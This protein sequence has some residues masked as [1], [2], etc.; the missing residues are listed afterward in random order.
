MAIAAPLAKLL[1][2]DAF[3]WVHESQT[4]FEQLKGAVM[5]APVLAL[6][7]FTLPFAVETDTSSHAMGAILH[8]QGHP[9]A[10][11][12]KPFC[13]RLQMA[14]TYVR[15]LHAIVAAVRKWRQ[16]LLGHK[17]TIYT[18]HCSLCELMS[19][20]VQ[21]PSNSFIWLSYLALI[22]IFSIRQ[23]PQMSLLTLSH[24]CNLQ[25]RHTT[26]FFPCLTQTS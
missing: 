12:S 14:S 11:F 23:E 26:F 5:A 17:F 21:T 2:K 7:N 20:V 16:Y 8:Q 3:K 13:S 4:A 9:I 1:C 24:A 25:R 15:E 10:F 6:P 19:Q 18:D 22:M